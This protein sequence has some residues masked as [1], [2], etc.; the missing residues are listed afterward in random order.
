MRR[1]FGGFRLSKVNTT[2]LVAG[3]VLLLVAGL[4][5]WVTIGSNQIL[6]GAP[7]WVRVVLGATGLL[8]IALAMATSQKARRGGY[9]RIRDSSARRPRCQARTGWLS[10]RTCRRR[11]WRHCALEGGRWR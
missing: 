4:A 11:S 1:S 8:A 7:W 3:A 9:G 10:A 5:R 2:L 6:P